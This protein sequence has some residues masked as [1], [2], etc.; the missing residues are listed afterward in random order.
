VIWFFDGFLG[1][2]KKYGW[3]VNNEDKYVVC[4]KEMSVIRQMKLLKD[5][6]HT[7]RSIS[8]EI[9]KSTNKKFDCGWVFRIL[10]RERKEQSY[11]V[12]TRLSLF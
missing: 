1:G 9:S 2:F 8:N 12:W 10:K 11:N 7:Y 3:D 4:E 6:D 5:Q